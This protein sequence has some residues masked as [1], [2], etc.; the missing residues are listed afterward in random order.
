[1]SNRV[2]RTGIAFAS[3]VTMGLVMLSL[4]GDNAS[5]LSAQAGSQ[6]LLACKHHEFLFPS[7]SNMSGDLRSKTERWR[8]TFT[9]TVNRVVRAHIDTT[10]DRTTCMGGATIAPSNDLQALARSLP[11]WDRGEALS[12][13]DLPAVLLAYEAAYEC[14][15][16]WRSDLL[17]TN[18]K[19]D[20]QSMPSVPGTFNEPGS[21]DLVLTSLAT[22]TQEERAIIMREISVAPRTMHKLLRY[23]AGVDRFRSLE[24]E[25]RCLE[26]ASLDIRNVLSLNA[27]IAACSYARE[28]QSSLKDLAE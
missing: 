16:N 11:P 3:V 24:S 26:R 14:A 13:Y 22:E 10:E 7:G 15:L 18:V 23:L 19:D 4:H 25:L 12:E 20:A 8:D 5:G 17:F 28:G 1:M 21:N 6:D 27:D 2:S 9:S